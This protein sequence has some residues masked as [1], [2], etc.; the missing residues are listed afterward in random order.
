MIITK[1]DSQVFLFQLHKSECFLVSLF[2]SDSKL[3]RFWLWGK[4][5]DIWGSHLGLWGTLIDIF[6]YFRKFY[7]PKKLTDKSRNY[8]KLHWSKSVIKDK[9]T[10]TNTHTQALFLT[11][12]QTDAA[13]IIYKPPNQSPILAVFHRQWPF[14][15]TVDEVDVLVY[16]W[17]SV[18]VNMGAD[19]LMAWG[20][21]QTKRKLKREG[22]VVRNKLLGLDNVTFSKTR[23]G[24]ISQNAPVGFGVF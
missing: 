3:I 4:T 16:P 17:R 18:W 14:N 15:L 5:Q 19:K 6:E 1:K 12:T 8:Q 13:P 23:V 21:W 22:S 11:N 24:L 2:L 20:M 10:G 7:R 9:I